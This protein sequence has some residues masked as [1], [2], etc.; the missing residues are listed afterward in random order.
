MELSGNQLL[1]ALS[2]ES[3]RA[4]QLEERDYRLGDVLS[5]SDDAPEHVFFPR[6][7]TVISIVRA[8]EEGTMV[9][10]GVIGDE[11]LLSV[12]S[13]IAEPEP[14]GNE[15]IVQIPGSIA[16]APIARVRERFASDPR[17][18]ELTLAFTSSFLGQLTQNLVCNRLHEIEQ[19]LAKWLLIARDRSRRDDLTL[20]Q[21]FLS[22]MLG[23]H[24]PGVSIAVGELAADGLVEQG[25]NRILIRDAEGLKRRSC[26]C[27]GVLHE[28]LQ[29]LPYRNV[30]QDTDS[31]AR[32]G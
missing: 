13:L 5:G 18:R 23:V 25:R 29:K 31:A 2:A 10:S 15:S 26:E 22:H 19:R 24:R 17:L 14:T 21:E 32:I 11:G 3:V 6:C 4:L 12:Q 28:L 9:E 8:T 27:Y 1:A 16:R 20:T 30:R 7:G